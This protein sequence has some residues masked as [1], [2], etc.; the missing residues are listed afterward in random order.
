MMEQSSLHLVS[1]V[2]KKLSIPASAKDIYVSAWFR[3][4]RIYVEYKS[5]DWFILSAMHG[6]VHPDQV[7]EPYELTLNRMA[8]SAR[9]TWAT[10]VLEQLLP[11]LKPGQ[12]V[13]ILAGQKYRE[14][15]E[16]WLQNESITV[17]VPMAG[18]G[19]GQQLK[20]LNDAVQQGQT[21]CGQIDYR[22]SCI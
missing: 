11:H 6:I 19:I 7:I 14:F 13:T 15:L 4:A 1:C 12:S 9:K 20:W 3:K 8:R 10:K 16:G 17:H 22:E 5:T 18:L 2:G 21:S